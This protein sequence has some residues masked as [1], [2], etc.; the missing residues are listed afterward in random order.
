MSK[1]EF[2]KMLND[3]NNGSKIWVEGKNKKQ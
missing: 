3:I 2:I 1:E